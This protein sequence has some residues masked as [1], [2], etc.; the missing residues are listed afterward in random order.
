[1]TE[2]IVEEVVKIPKPD[3]SHLITEDD[4]PVDNLFSAK[5]QRLLVEPL[6]SA[7]PL[8]WPFLADAN[9]GIFRSVHLPAIVPDAFLSLGVEPAEDW[10]AKEHRSY[11]IW[12]FG[13][14]PE[15]VIEVV[16]NKKGGELGKKMKDYAQMGIIYYAVYDPQRLIQNEIF[17]VYELRGGKYA[18]LEQGWLAEVELGLTVWEGEFEGRQ[19]QWLRWCDAGKNVIP[20]GAELAKWERARAEREQKRA[21]REQKRAEREAARAERLA[22]QLRALGVDP[23]PR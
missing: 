13:K 22:E 17:R 7:R 16:S 8:S 10:Y 6:Y 21:N 15:A 5:Q 3:V 18:P 1:M 14:S 2:Y 20:T 19:D 9:V 4:E 12:E 11:F 23:D